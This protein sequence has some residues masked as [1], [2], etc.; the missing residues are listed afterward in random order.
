MLTRTT[1][2]LA[3][4]VILVTGVV[5]G[6]VVSSTPGAS[7]TQATIITLQNSK[8]Y[9]PAPP[10]GATDDYHCTLLDP[11]LT[12]NMEIVGSQFFAGATNNTRSNEVHHAI[13]F[14]VPPQYVPEAKAAN[15]GGHG[16]TCFGETALPH[17]FPTGTGGGAAPWL[18]AWAPGVPYVPEPAGTGVPFPKGSM[19]IM[20]VHYNTL[21]THVPEHPKLQLH[22]VPASTSLKPLGLDLMPAPPDVPCPANV[23]GPLCNRQAA[24]ASLAQR[25]GRGQVAFVDGIEAVCGRN[26]ANPPAG[27][28][29]SCTWP[30]G[31]G[32]EILRTAAHMH[33]L[34]RQ[35]QIVLDPG[36]PQARTLLN[37]TNYDFNDQAPYNL[38]PPVITKPGDK[39]QVTC[40]YDPKLAQELPQLRKKA[41]HFVTWGDGSSDEMCLALI[42][43]IAAP[44]GAQPSTSTAPVKTTQL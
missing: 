3:A 2:I 22:V 44:A 30:I 24:L 5:V 36:T 6:L 14:L 29:T 34:G 10:Q 27:D 35:M 19:V 21:I 28:T 18:A 11:H 40:T 17:T 20:Q 8:A 43:S 39:V 42:Q 25:T 1:R 12:S 26:P 23:S 38:N 7:A 32:R 13:L 31:G 4:L 15:V 33:L 41:P 37:V 16:W 9:T